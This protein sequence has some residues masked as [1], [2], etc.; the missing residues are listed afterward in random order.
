M[1]AS[2]IGPWIDISR[3]IP[4]KRRSEKGPI[5]IEDLLKDLNQ[6]HE[7]KLHS[8]WALG[9]VGSFDR[10]LIDPYSVEDLLLSYLKDDKENKGIRLYS[11]EALGK[12]D[13]KSAVDPLI[14]TLKLKDQ[15]FSRFAVEALGRI[16]DP[17]TI[18]YIGKLIGHNDSEFSI[19]S[20]DFDRHEVAWCA[21][22]ALDNMQHPDMIKILDHALLTEDSVIRLYVLE[23][24]NSIDSREIAN[25]QINPVINCLGD[26]E[27]QIKLEA[28]KLLGK[29]RNPGAADSLIKF[30]DD[31]KPEIRMLTAEALGAIG[32][33]KAVEP[34]VNCL[35]IDE[36][37][38][39]CFYAL[40]ALHQINDPSIPNH[41]ILSM[42]KNNDPGI[43]STILQI[44]VNK[45]GKG[46]VPLLASG[47]C[48]NDEW[49]VSRSQEAMDK[50]DPLLLRLGLIDCTKEPYDE[51]IREKAKTLLRNL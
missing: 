25:I 22:S 51:N 27:P 42:F 2:P 49:I 41:L 43:R 11:A 21:I 45:T 31:D 20:G 23:K 50:L 47:L 6:T 5:T 12:I 34:L 17:E 44:L 8:V 30:L 38:Q 4:D 1:F 9:E 3:F 18:G 29:T 46:V 37:Q 14:E 28:I 7:S 36:K 39:V 24:L 33:P 16:K 19:D 13:S 10:N 35:D 26:K 15:A 48:S 32:D 40:L